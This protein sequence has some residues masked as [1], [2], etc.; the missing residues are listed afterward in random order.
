MRKKKNVYT[1]YDACIACGKCFDNCPVSAIDFK[2]DLFRYDINES[3]CIS[4]GKCYR[5]CVY[6]SILKKDST[7]KE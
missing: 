3:K 2:S 5:G 1:I 4:C 6:K 7:D